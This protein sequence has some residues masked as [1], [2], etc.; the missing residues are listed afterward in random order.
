MRFPVKQWTLIT[1]DKLS[2][3]LEIVRTGWHPAFGGGVEARSTP[4]LQLL[5]PGC[6]QGW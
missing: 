4:T 6:P 3:S 5:L 2:E 1:L